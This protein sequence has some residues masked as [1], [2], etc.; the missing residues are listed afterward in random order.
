MTDTDTGNGNP[1]SA[2][3]PNEQDLLRLQKQTEEYLAGWKRAKADYLNLRKDTEKE[4]AEFVKF[5]NAA[6]LLELLPLYGDLRR[7]IGQLPPDLAE[8]EWAK[9]ICHIADNFQ[10]LMD[11]FGIRQMETQGVRFDPERHEAVKSEK[12]DGVASGTILE[13]LAPG[14]HLHDRVL[15]PS[16]VKV[17]L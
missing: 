8:H 16:K 13:E 5:A 2:I 6:L 17:A 7:A 14:F 4:K 1:A 11:A 15:L 10:K 3:P 9:G 12:R